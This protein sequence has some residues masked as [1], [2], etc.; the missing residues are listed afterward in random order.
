MC[1]EVKV[2]YEVKDVF[3][4]NYMQYKGIWPVAHR[5]FVNVSSKTV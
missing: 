5:D 1:L 2:L 4:V 3:K